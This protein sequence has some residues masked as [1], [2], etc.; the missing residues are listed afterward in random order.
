MFELRGAVLRIFTD[1]T[2]DV[3]PFDGGVHRDLSLLA[4]KDLCERERQHR[5]N[6]AR[7]V[8]EHPFVPGRIE[9][10]TRRPSTSGIVEIDQQKLIFVSHPATQYSGLR[11]GFELCDGR[12]VRSSHVP[13]PEGITPHLEMYFVDPLHVADVVVAIEKYY[14][15]L[16]WENP[17]GL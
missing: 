17:F 1:F 5:K 11:L 14:D 15:E 2:E 7:L 9:I 8:I 12:I 3:V 16:N 13:F 4:F 6:Q 10:P